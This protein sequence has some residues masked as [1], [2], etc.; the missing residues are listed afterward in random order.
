MISKEEEEDGEDYIQGDQKLCNNL[1]KC[2]SKM[3]HHKCPML[4]NK[5]KYE[6][7]RLKYFLR[8][9]QIFFLPSFLIT[10][11]IQTDMIY[12][13]NRLWKRLAVFTVCI[14]CI[15]I[16]TILQFGGETE[17]YQCLILRV[18]LYLVH[19]LSFSFKPIFK[20]Y[21]CI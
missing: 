12:I 10:L 17:N 4:R 16:S 9:K 14:L 5:K 13:W 3:Q 1:E 21:H 11:Y 20:S 8:Y 15:Y 19:F 2:A 18:T 7:L 6:I